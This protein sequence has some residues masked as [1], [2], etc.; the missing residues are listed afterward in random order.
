VSA[1]SAPLRRTAGSVV[2]SR[3]HLRVVAAPRPRH[4]LR[5][6]LL[7]LA[8]AGGTVFGTVSLNALA[9]EDAVVA[10]RLE[11][12][13]VVAERDYARLVADV[14][15]LEDPARIRAA[16]ERLGMVAAGSVRFLPVERT[17][18]ADGVLPDLVASGDEA[19]DPL[20]PVLSQER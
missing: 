15:A 6:V 11:Q 12:Q 7:S 13:V 8:L 5:Y 4:R 2:R 14:A 1:A 9:A 19:T 17:L 10:R 18:P 20:K 16:A 3:G